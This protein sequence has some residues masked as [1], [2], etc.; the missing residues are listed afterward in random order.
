MVPAVSGRWLTPFISGPSAQKSSVWIS[1]AS[2]IEIVAAGGRP[3]HVVLVHAPRHLNLALP[4]TQVSLRILVSRP[5]PPGPPQPDPPDDYVHGGPV[6]QWGPQTR[7]VA[8]D[9][10]RKSPVRAVVATGAMLAG[11]P[12]MLRRQGAH[13][14]GPFPRAGEPLRPEGVPDPQPPLLH[15][16]TIDWSAS[17]WYERAGHK[18]M[19]RQLQRWRTPQIQVRGCTPPHPSACHAACSWTACC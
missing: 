12:E 9:L 1:G 16:P 18:H 14:A 8:V 2:L 5:P 15:L 3:H 11:L 19:A 4:L 13:Q 10:G 17:R 7:F 6:P